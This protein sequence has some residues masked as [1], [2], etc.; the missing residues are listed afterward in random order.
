MGKILACSFF[1]GTV[2]V[3]NVL[4]SVQSHLLKLKNI[5]YQHA[6]HGRRDK[7]NCTAKNSS[8]ILELISDIFIWTDT[9]MYDA[10]RASD[11]IESVIMLADWIQCFGD[12]NLICNSL[13][14]SGFQF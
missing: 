3:S 5:Y 1:H 11:R 7:W 9:C 4:N 10:I 14:G 6:M 8:L 12:S 2:G 13:M